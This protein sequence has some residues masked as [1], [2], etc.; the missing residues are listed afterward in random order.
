M[1]SISSNV[2]FFFLNSFILIHLIYTR[3]YI[4]A[5]IFLLFYDKTNCIFISKA[6]GNPL[7][8]ELQ[9]KAWDAVLPLV[10]RLKHFY[11]FSLKLG[12]NRFSYLSIILYNGRGVQR[13]LPKYPR[14]K[15]LK[16]K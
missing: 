12:S 16:K 6:I 7:N 4:Y 13:V 11:E 1:G 15:N 3:T 2:Y 10:N 9:I 14:E 5:T 8:E